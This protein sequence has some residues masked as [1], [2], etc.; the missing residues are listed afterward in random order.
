MA[1]KIKKLKTW[2]ETNASIRKD[3]GNVKP[4]TQIHES[5][6]NKKPKYKKDWMKENEE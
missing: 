2:E 6:K 3:W 5:K 1:D 4:Y